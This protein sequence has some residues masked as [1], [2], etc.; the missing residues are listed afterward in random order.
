MCFIG[1]V[2]GTIWALGNVALFST[3]SARISETRELANSD[4][5]SRDMSAVASRLAG[6]SIDAAC[7]HDTTAFESGETTTLG[8]VTRYK[9]IDPLFIRRELHYNPRAIRLQPSVCQDI[10]HPEEYVN[11]LD[12]KQKTAEAFMIVIH[13]ITHLEQPTFDETDTQCEAIRTMPKYL[14]S[15][16]F[17]KEF[18]E[19]AGDY[20]ADDP[21]VT[22]SSKYYERPCK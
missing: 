12:R 1:A 20:V 19:W 13:E 17:E 7:T 2:Y 22:L 21:L 9:V 8:T 6:Y 10:L 3:A 15:Y 4:Q 5:T 18:A 14:E 16:G 11:E